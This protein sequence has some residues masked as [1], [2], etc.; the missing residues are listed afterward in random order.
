MVPGS[1]PFDREKFQA[2][3]AANFQMSVHNKD[4]EVFFKMY[5][6]LFKDKV[7]ARGVVLPHSR[8]KKMVKVL[9]LIGVTRV[10]GAFKCLAPPDCLLAPECLGRTPA[11]L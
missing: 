8:W 5:L 11:E 7:H 10:E 3:V 4:E 9:N 2:A 1:L 6:Q